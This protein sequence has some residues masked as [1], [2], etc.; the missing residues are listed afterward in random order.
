M[1]MAAIA[2]ALA[3]GPR[4]PWLAA[5]GHDNPAASYPAW[6]SLAALCPHALGET[7]EALALAWHEVERAWG[8]A[9]FGPVQ[10][11]KGAFSSLLAALTAVSGP[12][13]AR[14]RLGRAGPTFD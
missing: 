13:W 3:R 7:E 5:S 1:S 12:L 8:T 4:T 9:F 14:S 6:R 11:E 10:A 2:K